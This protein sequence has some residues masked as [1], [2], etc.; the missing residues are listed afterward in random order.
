MKKNSKTF[1][2]VLLALVVLIG[3]GRYPL[4]PLSDGYGAGVLSAESPQPDTETSEAPLAPDFTVYDREGNEV[5]LSA[6]I[7]KPVVTLDRVLAGAAP[8]AARCRTLK[9]PIRNLAMISISSW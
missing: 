1:L 7:G 8:A 3:A 2:Y 4:H 6:F 5:Q 9:P